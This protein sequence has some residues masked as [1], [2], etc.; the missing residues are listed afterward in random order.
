MLV[1]SLI[2]VF[3]VILCLVLIAQ[4]CIMSR[5]IIELGMLI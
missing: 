4:N 1:V 3:L 5:Q 2:G